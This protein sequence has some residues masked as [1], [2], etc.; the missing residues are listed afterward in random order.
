MEENTSMACHVSL[1]KMFIYFL[2]S[3]SSILETSRLKV[4]SSAEVALK[5]YFLLVGID[6]HYLVRLMKPIM[7]FCSI[8]RIGPVVRVKAQ[9]S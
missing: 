9:C 5:K 7:V 8:G 4:A 2:R 3:I 1:L 6:S